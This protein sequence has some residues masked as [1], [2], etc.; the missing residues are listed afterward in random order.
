MIAEDNDFGSNGEIRYALS[1]D[2]GDVGNVFTIDPFTGWIM[3]L[4]DLDRE[5]QPIYKFQVLAI[6]NSHQKH[7]NR[8]T[9]IIRLKDYND[10][11]PVFTQEIYHASIK[12]NA[13]IGNFSMFSNNH[14]NNNIQL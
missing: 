5:N 11:P 6:D 13:Q 4:V 14:N 8:T 10:C 2:M 7:V 3:T 1:N 9:V 12:E